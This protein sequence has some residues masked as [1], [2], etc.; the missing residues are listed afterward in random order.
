MFIS[1]HGERLEASL[2]EVPRASRMP[3]RVAPYAAH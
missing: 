1:L 3:V 2:E